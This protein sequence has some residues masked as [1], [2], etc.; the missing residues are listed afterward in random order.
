MIESYLSRVS[1]SNGVVAVAEV[2]AVGEF[3]SQ[4]F[5]SLGHCS[6][7]ASAKEG[8][9]VA[10][11]V[12]FLLKPGEEEVPAFLLFVPLT[13]PRTYKQLTLRCFFS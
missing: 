2:V 7:F 9:V 8:E 12:V 4:C 13:V 10:V 3:Q 1:F 6:Q 11:A 5:P